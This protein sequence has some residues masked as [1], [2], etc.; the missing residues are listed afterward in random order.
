MIPCPNP[1][2]PN[3]GNKCYKHCNHCGED[4]LWRPPLLDREIA[5]KGPKPLEM[6]GRTV[7]RCMKGGTKDGKYYKT[8]PVEV[9]KKYE[10]PRVKASV[11]IC[12]DPDCNIPIVERTEPLIQ[13]LTLHL[14]KY[15][16]GIE[17]S[18]SYID[19]LQFKID[20]LRNGHF[21]YTDPFLHIPWAEIEKYTIITK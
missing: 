9:E 1:V 17:L 15:H 2:C 7:H 14:K 3:Y 12:S 21:S 6:D 4:I 18:G 11:I 19:N 20:L 16:N 10:Y 8:D 13:Q 5:Y